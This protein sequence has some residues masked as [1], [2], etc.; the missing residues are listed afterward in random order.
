M[1]AGRF[2]R[3]RKSSRPHN[4]IVAAFV[5]TRIGHAQLQDAELHE[6]AEARTML[7]A[8]PAAAKAQPCC[9]PDP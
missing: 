2:E 1:I 7:I 3:T 9:L 4:A 8:L 6:F 5:A